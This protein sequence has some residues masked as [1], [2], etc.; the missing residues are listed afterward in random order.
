MKMKFVSFLIF[1]TFLLVPTI[2]FAEV[3]DGNIEYGLTPGRI[4]TIVAA[5]VG[6][7]S[8]V[9]GGLSLTR[10]ANRFNSCNR[11]A[12]AIVALIVG[13]IGIVLAGLH[14]VNSTGGFGTGN[15]RAG[16]IVAIVIGLTGM[17]LAGLTLVRYRRDG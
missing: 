14:L 7:I 5:V 2:A 1:Y 12:G 16:A 6:L 15:G 17:V 11:R 8:V 3:A 13:L 4:K 9:I 10:F